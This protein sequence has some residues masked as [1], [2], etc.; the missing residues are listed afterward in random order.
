MMMMGLQWGPVEV[1]IDDS[2][3]RP[4]VVSVEFGRGVPTPYAPVLILQSTRVLGG[5]VS[6]YLVLFCISS[7]F[8]SRIGP[9]HIQICLVWEGC[10][11]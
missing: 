11:C 7:L 4:S 5:R 1:T 10:W 2:K 9:Y 3:L 8:Q 6:N